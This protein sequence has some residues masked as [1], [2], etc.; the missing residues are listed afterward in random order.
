MTFP[1]SDE[2]VPVNFYE[3][4]LYLTDPDE[5]KY[6]WHMQIGFIDEKYVKEE[7]GINF[8]EN[9]LGL[10]PMTLATTAGS[11]LDQRQFLT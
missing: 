2:T 5:K 3:I 9:V 8:N 7:Y 6:N 1:G 10:A 11:N 4:D